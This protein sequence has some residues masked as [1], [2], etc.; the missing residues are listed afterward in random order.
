MYL[1]IMLEIAQN[2]HFVV[3][4]ATANSVASGASDL[5]PAFTLLCAGRES[6][7]HPPGGAIIQNALFC[8]I[9]GFYLSKLSM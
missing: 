4:A 3:A 8:V 9:S 7:A 1:F 2:I 6:D 5:R